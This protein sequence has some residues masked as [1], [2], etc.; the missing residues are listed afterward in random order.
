VKSTLQDSQIDMESPHMDP[1]VVMV[2]QHSPP[3]HLLMMQAQQIATQPPFNNQVLLLKNT[4]YTN[5]T[6]I[7][8]E[9]SYREQHC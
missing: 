6:R 1:A 4:F 2:Q 7:Q 5:F 9:L 3:Q 8:C